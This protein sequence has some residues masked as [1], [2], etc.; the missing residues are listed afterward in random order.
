MRGGPAPHK[1][2]SLLAIRATCWSKDC[3][4]FD[5]KKKD[6]EEVSGEHAVKPLGEGGM[7]L[8]VTSP[9]YVCLHP[10][11]Y[12]HPPM[13]TLCSILQMRKLRLEGKEACPRSRG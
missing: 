9:L 5:L 11:P 7:S 8:R 10:R 2:G 13:E 6:L 3:S 4:D 12:G 1:V